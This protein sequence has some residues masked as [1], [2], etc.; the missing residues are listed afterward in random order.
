MEEGYSFSN[1][2]A[3][4]AEDNEQSRSLLS[5][6][7]RH[8]GVGR[9][10]LKSDG[11]DAIDFLEKVNNGTD[12]EQYPPIEAVFAN[13]DM[14]HVDG[15]LLL[16]WIRRHEHSPNRFMP[17][18]LLSP[19]LNKKKVKEA[20]NAGAHEIIPKPFP[21]DAVKRVLENLVNYHRI[22]VRTPVY[23]GPDRR[24]KK[25]DVKDTER[26]IEI[27]TSDHGE[28]E[29]WTA[30]T[31]D[32]HFFK[33][34]NILQEKSQL[35]DPKQAAKTKLEL[36][37]KTEQHLNEC[38]EDYADWVSIKIKELYLH[39]G[40]ARRDSTVIV[41]C[42]QELHKTAQEIKAQ[43][44]CFGYPLLSDLAKS[45]EKVTN[46]SVA[47]SGKRLDLIKTHISAMELIVKHKLIGAGGP[48]G[49]TIL[50][51]LAEAS[52]KVTKS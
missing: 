40:Q 20:I 2:S 51:S 24:R 1:I 12:Q 27:K 3:I 17:F 32:I 29:S 52:K 44:V 11:R 25:V 37:A 18:I 6:T 7:L 5:S 30:D 28:E 14:G 4:V 36:G 50:D 35:T 43:G 26:R 31:P 45:L 42:F 16:K 10:I 15:M 13:W 46:I 9:V 33:V 41:Q 48:F 39:L 22:F 8:L 34:P 38:S 49:K 19:E 47:A 23:F 21:G